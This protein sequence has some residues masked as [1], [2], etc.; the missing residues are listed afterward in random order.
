[1]P[2]PEQVKPQPSRPIAQASQVLDFTTG[3]RAWAGQTVDPGTILIM[4]TKA[5]DADLSGVVDSDDYFRIDTG[6]SSSL[7]GYFNGDFDLNGRID[8]DDYFLIDR[9]YSRAGGA[10]GG[11]FAAVTAVPEPAVATA[12]LLAGAST[13]RRRRKGAHTIVS[14]AIAANPERTIGTTRHGHAPK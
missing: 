9:S 4:Y 2:A 14:T 12:L 5:G 13:L 3:T 7:K 6:F 11:A 8:G 1:M 10:G